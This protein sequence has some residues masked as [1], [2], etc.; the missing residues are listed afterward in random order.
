MT[1]GYIEKSLSA[2]PEDIEKINTFTRSDFTGESLYIFSV[3]LCD[4]D[5]D[6]DYEKFSV[7]ALQQMKNLFVGKTGIFDHS[8]KSADQKARIFDTW[9]EQVQGARTS[10][11]EQLYRLRA[12]AYMVKSDENMPLI[13]EIEAGIKKEISISCAA[14]KS[15][16]SVCGRDRR[17]EGC[18]H[19]GGR[20]YDGK[21][22][23]FTLSDI[24]DAYEFSFVAVP[25]QRD[26][27][28]TKSFEILKDG[29]NMTDIIKNLKE[30]DRQVMLT[31]NQAKKLAAE[32]ERLDEEAQLGREYKKC[33]V[34][35]VVA[36]CSRAM[37]C[38][39]LKVF[40]GVAQIM[41]ARELDAF[42]AAFSKSAA[43][44]AQLRTKSEKSI[45]NVNQFKI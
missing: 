13:T 19:I 40:S 6:R 14:A 39:D 3:V 20:S 35:E 44:S 23:S 22:A 17:S 25:A 8:M 27:G 9:V 1:E 29:K 42:K 16:C 38:M 32:W 45:N 12:K 28:V 30:S 24:T 34:N 43:D 7:E 18:P 15:I 31:E 11:G 2:K 37:P 4:N 10:D 33:L 5:I 21:T 41:T 26:A 36:L